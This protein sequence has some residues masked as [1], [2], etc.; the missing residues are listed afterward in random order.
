MKKSATRTFGILTSGGDCPGLNA[1]IRGVAKAANQKYDMNIIGISEG[2]RGLIA[3]DARLLKPSDFSGILTQGGTILGTS[4]EKP[5]K[6]EDN[7]RDSQMGRKK[8]D[9]I[10][11]NYKKLQLDC[12]VVLGGNGTHKTACLLK[13]EGLN[14]IG[15]PKTIDNDI[16]GTDVTFGF[17]S[18]VD[19]ATE[20]IDRLHS[21]AHSHNRVMVIELMGHKA[22]WLSLYAGIAGGGD[23]ILIP[24][25]PYSTDSICRHLLNRARLG[26]RFSIV[27]VAEGAVSR[28]DS[29]LPKSDRK[30]K[31][32]N[33]DDLTIGYRI[34]KEIGESSGMETR[35]TVLGY[36]QR[37]GTPSPYDR[38]LAT[39][40]GT[41]A[42]DLLYR[43]EYGKMIALEGTRIVTK[44]LEDISG[45][46]KQVPADHHLID[47]ARSVGTCFGDE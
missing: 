28:K 47:T 6:E 40:F 8:S 9:A 23:V 1:A 21:T 24:E 30:K 2:Y 20:A 17:H 15:L 22:G 45:R 44:Q 32:K 36:Q 7:L 11:E 14:V 4:R 39:M 12:L 13:Q 27:V 25:I 31:K 33:N 41:A 18:A 26:K 5:F 10:L 16:W 42:A 38:L 3:G 19:I 46:L 29:S 34:A 43:G 37:G 35:L